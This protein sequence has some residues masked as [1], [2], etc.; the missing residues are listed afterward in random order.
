MTAEIDYRQSFIESIT[1]ASHSLEFACR[2][3]PAAA[4]LANPVEA[5][6]VLQ[7]CER[8]NTLKRDID[9]FLDAIQ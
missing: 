7:L 3:L 1:K 2:D 6:V 8:A 5:I 9:I 4:G